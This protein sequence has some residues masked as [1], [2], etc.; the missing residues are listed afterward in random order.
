MCDY[1]K[2][3]RKCKA[4][5]EKSRFK[6]IFL[7]K[8]KNFDIQVR[9]AK[10]LYW[11]KVQSN[12]LDNVNTNQSE[13]WKSIGKVGISTNKNMPMEVAL[14]D[15]SIS[16]DTEVVLDK[17]KTC[18]SELYNHHTNTNDSSNNVRIDENVEDEPLFNDDITLFEIQKAV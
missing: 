16:Y 18:F 2:Q 7:D 1:E 8:R 13:F 15:R 11:Y 10:G 4:L 9:R 3:W 14:D 12:L 17:W 5:A 6:R